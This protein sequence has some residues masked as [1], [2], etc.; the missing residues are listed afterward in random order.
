MTDDAPSFCSILVTLRASYV[1]TGE[2]ALQYLRM[3]GTDTKPFLNAR[4]AALDESGVDAVIARSCAGGEAV[5]EQ[6]VRA[7]AAV[8]KEGIVQACLALQ[9]IQEFDHEAMWEDEVRAAG[10]DKLLGVGPWKP[11]RRPPP[12]P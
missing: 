7:F 10:A 9:D 4:A 3:L 2:T 12:K 1:E 6:E 8:L 5:S 11:H